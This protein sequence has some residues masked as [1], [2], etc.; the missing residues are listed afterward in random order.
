VADE[1]RGRTPIFPADCRLLF[2]HRAPT[3]PQRESLRRLGVQEKRL[4]AVVQ[5]ITPHVRCH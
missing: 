2:V 3:T 1:D 5:G 4:K